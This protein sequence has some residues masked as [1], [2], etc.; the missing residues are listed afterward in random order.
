MAKRGNTGNSSPHSRGQRSEIRS[1][2]DKDSGSSVKKSA[3][4]QGSV[5]TGRFTPSGNYTIEEFPS[6][7]QIFEKHNLK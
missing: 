7:K 1:I 5:R 2:Y 3:A 6:L 4:S